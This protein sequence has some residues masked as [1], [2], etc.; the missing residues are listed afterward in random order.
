MQGDQ[1]PIAE[2]LNIGQR[3]QAWKHRLLEDDDYIEDLRLLTG[4]DRVFI[5]YHN[6][7]QVYVLAAW[8]Y[9]PEEL[10]GGSGI[11]IEIEVLGPTHPRHGGEWSLKTLA[12]ICTPVEEEYKKSVNAHRA[13]RAHEQSVKESALE[14]R[15]ALE[16]H[17]EKQGLH[18][19]AEGL[20]IGALPFASEAQIGS[21]NWN[22]HREELTNIAK[23]AGSTTKYKSGLRREGR[24]TPRHVE[25]ID[26]VRVV[27]RRGS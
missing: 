7:E 12:A 18:A 1:S 14:D 25:V 11:F 10:D 19:E 6:I 26:G 3:S 8:I 24:E 22:A 9:T 15:R 13:R 4:N 2:A 16:K 23:V 21:E 5:Y 27:T 20:R 17:Y